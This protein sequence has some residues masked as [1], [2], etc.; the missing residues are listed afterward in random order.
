MFSSTPQI[1]FSSILCATKK[2]INVDNMVHKYSILQADIKYTKDA[3][4]S[5][6]S[7]TLSGCLEGDRGCGRVRGGRVLVLSGQILQTINR[8]AL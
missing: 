4:I 1:I 6:N 2:E 7:L 8:H 3:A 5:M